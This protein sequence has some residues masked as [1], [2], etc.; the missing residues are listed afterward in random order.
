[1]DSVFKICY[2]V[3]YLI[4]LCYFI[5]KVILYSSYSF[6]PLPPKSNAFLLQLRN[7]ATHIFLLVNSQYV[8][9]IHQFSFCNLR[10]RELFC[11]NANKT[12][13]SLLTSALYLLT[14]CTSH[15]SKVYIYQMLLRTSCVIQIMFFLYWVRNWDVLK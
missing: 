3:I 9:E 13:D 12:W 4:M 11:W 2:F 5:L 15:T 10:N 8:R 7:A 6:C 1:L 14:I